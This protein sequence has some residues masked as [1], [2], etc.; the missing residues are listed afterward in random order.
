MT[1]TR[2]ITTDKE[3]D[4]PVDAVWRAMTDSEWLAVWFFP[5]DIKPVEKHSF[6]I[7]SRPIE[8]WDGEF[9]CKVLEVEDRKMLKFSWKGGHE[10]L[11][12]F[13]HYMDVVVTWT[14]S[15][16]PGGHTHFHFVQEGIEAAPAADALYDIMVKGADS[17]LR[18]LAKRLPDLL[19]H[20]A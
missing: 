6:T 9:Q 4:H 7:W 18:S 1:E 16:L 14:I 8:R 3:L 19:E 15:E 5:N 12:A 17:V 10:E 13:G 20:D 11:K 2:S